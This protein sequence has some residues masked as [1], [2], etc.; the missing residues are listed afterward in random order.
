MVLQSYFSILLNIGVYDERCFGDLFG[1]FNDVENKTELFKTGSGSFR[2]KS[3]NCVLPM[4]TVCLN[5]GFYG[6]RRFGCIFLF[7]VNSN[8]P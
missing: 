1:V 4:F 6:E 8:I 5:I 7:C 2:L 3:V